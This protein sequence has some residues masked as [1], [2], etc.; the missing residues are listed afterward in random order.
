MVY[1]AIRPD[2]GAAPARRPAC[3]RR[4][5]NNWG[6]GRPR[7]SRRDRKGG[8]PRCCARRLPG[9]PRAR[10]RP[11][12]RRRCRSSSLRASPRPAPA[13]ATA[14]ERISASSSTSRDMMKPA[15]ADPLMRAMRDDVAV[16]QQALDFLL[17]PAAPER[18]GMQRGDCRGVA[19]RSLPTSAGSAAREQVGEEADHRRAN[20]AAFCGWASGARR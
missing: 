2:R 13:R 5:D 19:A 6:G 8:S 9:T 15:M 17:A 14:T 10:P 3:P 7:E 11:A 4:P 12:S 20:C 16:G 1:R 18:G